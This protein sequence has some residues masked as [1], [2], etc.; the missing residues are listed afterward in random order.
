MKRN[1]LNK[2]L[3]KKKE[4]NTTKKIL[5][6]LREKPKIVTDFAKDYKTG[7]PHNVKIEGY[8]VITHYKIEM[9][10]EK[11][12]R[13]ENEIKEALDTLNEIIEKIDDPL[14]KAIFEYRYITDMRFEEIAVKTNNSYENVRQI[15]YRTLKKL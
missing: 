5:A 11:R 15:H 4:L 3:N 10:E 14:A 1:I 9:Y 6:K 12:V 7:Y 13:L 2:Y 8:D